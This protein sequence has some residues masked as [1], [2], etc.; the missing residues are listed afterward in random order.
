VAFADGRGDVL[1]TT[2]IIETGLDIPRANTILVWRPDRFGAAQLHQLRGRVGRGRRRGTAYLLT[3]PDAQLPP[4]AQKRLQTLIELDRLGA[5]FAV[6][7]RD[8]DLRG[9]GDLLGEAQAGHMRLIGVELY[10]HLLDRAVAETRTGKAA[11]DR[12][13]E[14]RVDVPASIPPD[15]VAEPEVR[16]NLYARLA[17]LRDLSHIEELSDEIE[18]RFG[19]PP[20]ATRNLFD[21]ARIG[22]MARTLGV[23]QVDAG[24]LGIALTFAPEEAKS[25]RNIIADS[26]EAHWSGDRLVFERPSETADRIS[27]VLAVMER[28]CK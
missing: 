9:A 6:S 3:D 12:A 7:R 23:V 20:A 8:L 5:G 19:P 2:N 21:L 16:I 14:V 26:R 27:I 18:D 15:Y 22:E 25:L 24:P 1:V 11:V 28:L 4:S 13:T 10:R 17:R